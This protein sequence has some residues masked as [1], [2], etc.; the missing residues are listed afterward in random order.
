MKRTLTAEQAAERDARRARF[1]ELAKRIRAMSDQERARWMVDAGAVVTIEGRALSPRNT[2][3]CY[4]QRQGVTMVGGFRQWL[5]AGRCVR[6]GEHGIGI[7]VP[8]MPGRKGDD[9]HSET[10][11]EGKVYFTSGTVFDV[12]QTDEIPADGAQ[13]TA[14]A[15]EG[16]PELELALT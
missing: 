12:T 15:P 7:L 2:L 11:A 1:Q 4:F 14:A 5:K 13:V 3:L 16:K 9:E 6:K 10:G 8:C